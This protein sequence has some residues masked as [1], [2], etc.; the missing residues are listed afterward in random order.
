MEIIASTNSGS[1][2]EPIPAGTH[3]ARCYSMVYLGTIKTD[4]QG[5]EKWLPKVR[6]TFELPL[7][8][9][10]F[11]EE[12]GEQPFV[13]SKEYTLSLGEKANLRKDL[14]SWRGKKFS[15]DEAKGFDIC[16][17]LGKEC[18]LSIV[19]TESK[20]N[21]Y[22]NIGNISG[23]AKG[24]TCPPQVNPTFEFSVADFDE[25]KFKI[26]P[27]FLQDKV[28]GSK[29]FEEMISRP[30]GVDVIIEDDLNDPLPF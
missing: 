7:E 19:H 18:M 15:E 16:K 6:I 1:N 3:V 29:E 24:M 25:D 21:I 28:K 13:I 30:E 11:K 27:Q 5:Q 26:L 10:V 9:K 8:T 17:L 23:L 20:G 4:F 22:A 12:N 14:E 2:Y